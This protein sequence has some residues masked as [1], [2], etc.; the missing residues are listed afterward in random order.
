MIPVVEFHVQSVGPINNSFCLVNFDFTPLN[1]KMIKRCKACLTHRDS[2]KVFTLT[3]DFGDLRPG[4][5]CGIPINPRRA[6]GASRRPPKVFR[7]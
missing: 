5:F 7:E 2:Q 3:L 6:G 1:F 4:Q